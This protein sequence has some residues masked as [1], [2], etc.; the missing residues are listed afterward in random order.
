MA[1]LR[2]LLASP[3]RKS[4]RC[5]CMQAEPDPEFSTVAFP[6]PEEGRATW[7][8]A[9]AM[10]DAGNVGLVMAN[11]P[12]ADRLAAAVWLKAPPSTASEA[13][14]CLPSTQHGGG[15]VWR[16]LSGN[17][18]GALLAHWVWTHHHRRGAHSKPAAMLASTVIRRC[19]SGESKPLGLG[20]ARQKMALERW[21]NPK[22]QRRTCSPRCGVPSRRGKSAGVA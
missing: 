5:I 15:G 11:D 14:A 18:I 19:K 17:E 13:A 3:S 2:E 7:A 1:T 12:D 4:K 16:P 8:L 9:L 21:T 6:N 20:T 22:P 10:A